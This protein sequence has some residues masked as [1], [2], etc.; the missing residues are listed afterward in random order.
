MTQRLK[1]LRSSAS[2]GH[3]SVNSRYL[4]A[5]DLTHRLRTGNYPVKNGRFESFVS[6][7]NGRFR[8]RKFLITN[9]LGFRID[10][11]KCMFGTNNK[12][13]PSKRKMARGHE[14][15]FRVDYFLQS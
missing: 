7:Q 14:N 15:T 13:G 3:D 2:N 12:E 5:F 1:T 6:P 9:G 10:L 11:E 8:Y 4:I